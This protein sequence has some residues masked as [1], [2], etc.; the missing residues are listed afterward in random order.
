[1]QD[2]N[3]AELINGIF[4]SANLSAVMMGFKGLGTIALVIY[5]TKI[6]GDFL[7]G[8]Q[9]I[10]FSKLGPAIIYAAALGG[11]GEINSAIDSGM[12]VIQKSFEAS[13]PVGNSMDAR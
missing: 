12:T 2:L 11:W 1:M 10:T 5:L 8:S 9:V 4:Q 3:V 7:A 13:V 6:I